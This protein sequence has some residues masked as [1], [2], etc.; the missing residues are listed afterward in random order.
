MLNDFNKN[1]HWL[2]IEYLKDIVVLNFV[3]RIINISFSLSSLDIYIID[4]NTIMMLLNLPFDSFSCYSMRVIKSNI[5]TNDLSTSL[6]ICTFVLFL[7]L[8]DEKNQ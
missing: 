4:K 2:I 7:N 8:I 3:M 6:L 5:T 1:I